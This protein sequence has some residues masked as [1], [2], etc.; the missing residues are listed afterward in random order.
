M[1]GSSRR[2][3]RGRHARER[4]DAERE[5][6]GARLHLVA[7]RAVVTRT[8]PSA[9]SMRA[10]VAR[11]ALGHE[12][13]PEP[14]GVAQEVR[15]RQRLDALALSAP[16]PGLERAGAAWAPRGSCAPSRSAAACPAASAAARCAWARRTCG[17]CRA[18]R[19]C[20]ATDS[21]N[22]PG[23]DDCGV[24]AIHVSQLSARLPASFGRCAPATTASSWGSSRPGRR[25]RSPTSRAC[26]SA[27][28]ITC[29]DHTGVTA[30]WPHGGDPWA[31]LVLLRAR[32]R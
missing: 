30:V 22:G 12:R 7:R 6:G 25:T 27:T 26:A 20:A 13:P 5:H 18:G 17:R 3:Q 28:R 4:R 31:E 14:V 11:I 19:A 2:G 10:D 9:S 23:A 1:R 21:P 24:D 8:P 29:P 16:H 15:Q 32:P